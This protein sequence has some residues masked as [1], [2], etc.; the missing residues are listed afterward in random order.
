MAT[1]NN[2]VA[3]LAAVS[4]LLGIM[5]IDCAYDVP[6]LQALEWNLFPSPTA[7]QAALSIPAV[8]TM[9]S[10]YAHVT[11]AWFVGAAIISSI[12]VLAIGAIYRVAVIGGGRAWVLLLGLLV[13]APYFVLVM[14]PSE[15]AV[16]SATQADIMG[17]ILNIL[18]GRV[19]IVALCVFAFGLLASAPAAASKKKQQ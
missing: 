6:V 5:V 15:H 14:G 17:H 12:A 2:T 3:M 10:Y 18:R 19:I 1:L 13:A 16:G 8:G 9:T 7:S 11:K 4:V